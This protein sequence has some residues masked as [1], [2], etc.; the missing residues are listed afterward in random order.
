M[1]LAVAEVAEVVDVVLESFA[2]DTVL[3]TVL[4]TSQPCSG[5]CALPGSFRG[6]RV[7]VGRQVGLDVAD[8]WRFGGLWPPRDMTLLRTD[9]MTLAL[10]AARANITASR[11]PRP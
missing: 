11:A 9:K 10:K 1:A 3:R 5:A 4:K 6:D 7:D 2:L 8:V